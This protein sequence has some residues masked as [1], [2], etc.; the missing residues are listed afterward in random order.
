[1]T[2]S[3]HTSEQL[4]EWINSGVL[5]SRLKEEAI[6]V[7]ISRGDFQQSEAPASKPERSKKSFIASMG[8]FPL[9][10]VIVLFFILPFLLLLVE[11]KIFFAE[12]IPLDGVVATSL[13]TFM[14]VYT[15]VGAVI[16]YSTLQRF[17]HIKMHPR[18]SIAI[19]QMYSILFLMVAA[20]W[21]LLIER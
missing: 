12:K 4:N 8:R 19:F 13:M 3:N 21:M 5:S 2:L 14:A 6:E 11:A 7:L 20:S 10:R 15:T 17:K 18:R 9:G 16:V 1:M